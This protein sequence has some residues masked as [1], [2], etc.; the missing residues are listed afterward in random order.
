MRAAR[1][2]L[3][4]TVAGCGL[5]PGRRVTTE[6]PDDAREPVR[7]EVENQNYYDA[8]IYTIVSGERQRLGVVTGEQEATF[9]FPWNG[10]TARFL[11]HLVG[12]GTYTTETI[13]VEPGDELKLVVAPDLHRSQASRSR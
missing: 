1:A 5:W 9:S 10:P 12:A 7:V 4:L 2:L 8:T 3:A 11:I 13:S 6:R